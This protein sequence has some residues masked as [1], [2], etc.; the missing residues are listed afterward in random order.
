MNTCKRVMIVIGILIILGTIL[1]VILSPKKDVMK[2][3]PIEP[4]LSLLERAHA[5]WFGTNPNL[6]TDDARALKCEWYQ[7]KALISQR[8]PEWQSSVEPFLT[9][10]LAMA[11]EN[12]FPALY[13]I[14]E[15]AFDE[16]KPYYEGD[17]A[18][19]KAIRERCADFTPLTPD[20]RLDDDRADFIELAKQE[21]LLDAQGKIR[22]EKLPI[23]K[24]LHRHLWITLLSSSVPRAQ[25]ESPEERTTFLRWQ[26]ELSSLPVERK[27][28]KLEQ[29][30]NTDVAYDIDFAKAILMLQNGQPQDA[31][32]AL[33]N[34]REAA[35]TDFR[36]QRYE[37]AID[38]LDQAH[39]CNP[40]TAQTPTQGEQP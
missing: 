34:G 38:Q 8:S 28:Q 2:F 1:I 25:L 3:D 30:R 32:Q 6:D 26:V 24:L 23:A 9:D 20:L 17:D 13:W 18:Q 37:Q 29:F 15:E 39:A 11:S 33:R 36:I 4:Q 35:Q 19:G 22:P 27:L 12:G 14:G 40:Q 16:L 21:D 7:Y 31:C 10:A 5:S